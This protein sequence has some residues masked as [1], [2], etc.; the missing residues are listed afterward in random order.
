MK[1][2][3]TI[4][5]DSSNQDVVDNPNQ[6][7]LTAIDRARKEAAKMTF[8]GSSGLTSTSFSITDINGNTIGSAD[9]EL[10]GEDDD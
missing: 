3:L 2:E 4:K 5:I 7:V 10:E 9:L 6:T 1:F 8:Y